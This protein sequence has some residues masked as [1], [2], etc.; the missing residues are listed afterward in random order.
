[1]RCETLDP[2]SQAKRRWIR[3][4]V[5]IPDMANSL[6]AYM[7]E[8]ADMFYNASHRGESLSHGLFLPFHKN[9]GR[10]TNSSH[11]IFL[12]FAWLAVL[13]LLVLHSKKQASHM[14]KH[15]VIHGAFFCV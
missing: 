10:I 13:S 4:I 3:P 6:E 5:I 2:E 9:L 12:A 11:V 1:M 15:D 8:V 7:N 14:N